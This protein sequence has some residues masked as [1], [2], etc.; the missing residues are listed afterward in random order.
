MPLEPA[1]IYVLIREGESSPV[2]G[3]KNIIDVIPGDEG[4]NDFWEVQFVTVP[5][6]YSP[7]TV[8][9]Y[10]QIMNA[11]YTTSETTMLVNCPVVP[12]G[13]TAWSRLGNEE[14]GLTEGWYK[15]KIVY[16]FN[17]SEKALSV[18]GADQVPLSPIYVTF[19]IN[20]GEQGGGSASGFKHE[21][22]T[23]RAHNVVATLPEDAGY[24]PL[25]MVNVYDNVDFENVH[26]LQSALAANILANGVANVNCPVVLIEEPTGVEETSSLPQE[27][28]LSQNYPNPFNPTTQIKFAIA[29]SEKVSLK[30]YNVIGQQ[31]AEL[32]NEVLP[33]GNYSVSWNARNVS[34]GVYFYTIT[35]DHFS[36]SKKMVL[37]K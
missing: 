3:Q 6:D 14:P 35:T 4:Y 12:E 28:Q 25:W 2:E 19:N 24:S 16:Y 33:A 21:E 9:S 5:A 22:E 23:G 32:V 10:E 18:N 27:Y 1:P 8:T 7:N 15:N 37:L 20:P 36:A 34:S 26:D 13:S 11:G 30:I 29:N 31:V 17:F